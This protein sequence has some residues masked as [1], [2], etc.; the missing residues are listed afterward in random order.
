[1]PGLS[2]NR[3]A[4]DATFDGSDILIFGGVKRDAPVPREA[5]P[6]EVV[7]TVSGPLQ[8]LTVREAERRMGIW[9]NADSVGSDAAPVLL[10]RR[11]HRSA[12]SGAQPDRGPAPPDHRRPGGPRG[13][14]TRWRAARSS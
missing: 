5:A 4:I 11:H 10:R 3:V 12:G 7:I 13:R 9:V 8:R 1:V 14:A 2:S 6:L